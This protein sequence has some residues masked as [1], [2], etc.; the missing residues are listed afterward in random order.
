MQLFDAAGERLA[1]DDRR[2][3]GVFYPTGLWKVGEVLVDA[4]ALGWDGGETPARL[5]VGMYAGAD[6][7]PSPFLE[8][9]L[10]GLGNGK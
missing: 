1:Q 8:I 6:L 4:H 3:G 5:L 9:Q 2:P 7:R 10:P